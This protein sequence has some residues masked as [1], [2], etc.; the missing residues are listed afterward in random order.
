MK[1]LSVFLSFLLA[2]VFFEVG[3]LP[4]RVHVP[5][6]DSSKLDAAL[7]GRVLIEELNCVACHKAPAVQ[8][9]SRKSP[10][11]SLAGGRINPDYLKAF[12]Q[13]PHQ[14]KP[15]TLMPDFLGDLEPGE[16]AKVAEA[17]THYLVSLNKGQGFTVQAPDAVAAEQGEKLF[18]SVGC[19]ACHA[20]RDAGGG[21]LLRESSVPLGVLE[22]KYS[23]KGLSDFLRRP[24]ASRPSGRMPDLRLPGHEVERITHYLLRKTQVPGHLSYTT[25]RGKVW[26]G[27]K[28]EVQKEKAGQ[29]DDFT[30]EKIGG[31]HHQTA[32]EYKGFLNIRNAGDYT[33]HLEFNGGN[34]V[35]NGREVAAQAPSNRRGIKKIQAKVSL[36]AGWNKLALT[37]FHTG[38]DPRFLIEMEGPGFPRSAIP[39]AMLST[40]NE[41]IAVV[42]A[43][44]SDPILAAA[45]RE[46]FVR[47]G[48]AQCHDDIKADRREY[49]QMANLDVDKGCLAGQE[50]TPFFDLDDRQKA[51]IKAALP[52]TG[53]GKFSDR[54]MVDKTL[55]AFNCIACHERQGLGGI[56]P[57]RNAYFTG[58][59][60]AL[61]NQGRIPPP[62]THVG[63]K[64][65][66]SWLS[67]VL[68]R[69]GRQREYL[70]TRMPLFGEANVAHLV[71]GF[72]KIDKLEKIAYP[73]ITNIRE[74]KTA[75][76]EMI[77]STGLSCIACHDFNGQKSGGAGALELI[78][79][80]KR[81]KKNWFHLYM[82]QPS[83]FHPTVIMPSYWPGGQPIRRE[84]LGGDTN[85]QI[86]ALWD[87]LSDGSRAKLPTGLSRQSLQ[88]RV[89]DETV[90]CRGRGTAGYRGIG[91]G[92]P[93]RISL[94]FDSEQMALRQLW[95]GDFA[96]VNHGS[97]HA[98]G[99]DR[100]N[101]P[102]GIPFHRLASMDDPWPYKG[103]TNY[104]FP[105]DHGYQYRGYFLNPQKRPTFMYRYGEVAVEDFFEDD[106]NEKGEAFFRR[107]LTF[108]APAVQESFFFRVGS[109]KQISSAG[110]RQ[111]QI[112]RL[113]LHVQEGQEVRV[114]EGD[115]KELLIELALPKGKTVLQLEYRW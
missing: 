38:R 108:S 18:H 27:L 16:K 14:V 66:G 61:G 64:L 79:V 44:K 54:Q 28:G 62:L 48:C 8:A 114:R 88:L 2:A 35:I 24:H 113:R 59:R 51:L 39:P 25:W 102:E 65:T 72:E 55:V 1:K 71:E 91:V 82:R 20:P 5:G 22:Q 56:A 26:E 7:K 19:V 67:E 98:R 31:V 50:G 101:F 45:G 29:V 47:L 32:I 17:I 12:I 57:E 58:T 87:Y 93:E 11:L 6:I 112:D 46:H 111:W 74:S 15:G 69:G 100:V 76:Y 81:L 33:F 37:Y 75:G 86:E 90:M 92:Y 80:T 36:G 103:K 99:G 30:L 70:N 3:N 43:L 60:E 13:S 10:R 96:S 104:L 84:I 23:F 63:A 73:K 9:G 34:L 95:K 78:H 83:R 40:S 4:A 115:P 89:A 21:E 42:Q 53:D 68:L 107:R 77:G 97:F 52:G 105:Q 41:P 106:L 49:T 94:A 85:R 109:G 110:G